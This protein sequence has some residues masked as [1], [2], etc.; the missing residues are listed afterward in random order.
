MAS[1][2]LSLRSRIFIYMIS[3]VVVASILIAAVTIYQ[4]NEQSREYHSQ[5]LER[6]ESQLLSSITYVLRQTTY[7]RE[8]THLE[9]IF[10][11]EIFKI[12]DIHNVEFNIYDLEG[13]L[14]KSSRP[15]FDSD[16][17]TKCLSANILNN[18]FNSV[19]KRYVEKNEQLGGDYQSSFTVFTDFDSKPLGI[20]NVPYFEDDSFNNAELREFLKRLG[21]TYLF[22]LLVA[23]AFAFFAS[24]FTTKSSVNIRAIASG[25]II[26]K[27]KTIIAK[28]AAYLIAVEMLSST[29]PYVPAP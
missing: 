11:D 25:K 8:T 1:N 6:K 17:L 3:L 21:Y 24:R 22:M 5:R 4:Y 23:V 14:I 26:N 20:L 7:P 19:K 16:T 13:S 29:L 9:L 2:R 18:L 10:K 28:P 27:Q 15:K 12:A